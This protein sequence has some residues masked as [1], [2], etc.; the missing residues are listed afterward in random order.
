M[1]TTLGAPTP[2]RARALPCG[3]PPVRAWRPPLGPPLGLEPRAVTRGKVRGSGCHH[4]T[5]RAASPGLWYCHTRLR[6]GRCDRGLWPGV[7]GRSRGRSGG[8]DR[9]RRRRRKRKRSRWSQTCKRRRQRRQRKQ[10][11]AGALSEALGEA[12]A[13]ALAPAG[14][15]PM[16]VR[17]RRGA[18]QRHESRARAKVH[19][20]RLERRKRDRRARLRG[21]R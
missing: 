19:P 11:E 3:R 8:R 21:H 15:G 7:G 10:V 5:Q 6:H 9:Q 2:S 14:D 4:P 12:L 20:A 18:R 17:C 1:L 13:E 16:G